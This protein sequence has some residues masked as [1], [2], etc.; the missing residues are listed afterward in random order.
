MQAGVFIDPRPQ[1]ACP[2]CGAH[3][4]VVYKIRV[5]E[6]HLHMPDSPRGPNYC[7]LFVEDQAS[8]CRFCFR[9]RRQVN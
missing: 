6:L 4:G 5:Y 8:D 9:L 1:E 2:T 3:G 7:S